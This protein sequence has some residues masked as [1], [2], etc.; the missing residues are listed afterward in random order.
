MGNIHIDMRRKGITP[1]IATVLLLGIT[2]TIGLTLLTQAENLLEGSSDTGEIDQ[3]SSTSLSIEPIYANVSNG[4]EQIVA[5]IRNT[6]SVAVDGSQFTVNY[7]PPNFDTPVS[8]DSLPSGWTVSANDNECMNQ[9]V[10]IN[11]GASISCNTGV[12]FP[13]ALQSVEISVSAN[14]FDR[15]WSNT[16]SPSTS[17]SRSC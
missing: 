15:S 1:V 14:N 17:S 6:G 11:P 16:C 8:Y 13:G 12:R 3:V 10:I 5:N 4:T 9:S 7:G 2:I